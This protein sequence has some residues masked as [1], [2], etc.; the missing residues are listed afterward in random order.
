VYEILDNLSVKALWGSSYVPPSP[1]QLNG[2]MIRTNG[3]RG[4]PDLDSQT[5]NTVEGAV[6]YRYG[7]HVSLQ[8]TGFWTAIENRIESVSVGS[9]EEARNLTRSTTFGAEGVAELIYAPFFVKANVSWQQ[10]S[11]E[12]PED[13]PYWWSVV[14]DPDGPGGDAPPSA[15]GIMGHLW[16]G[17]TLPEYHV[18]GTVMLH[19]YGPRKATHQ[20]IVEAG[21]AYE[22]DPYVRLDLNLRTLQLELLGDRLTEVSLH[23]TNLLGTEYVEGGYLGVEIPAVGRTVFLK[24]TQ[25]F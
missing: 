18:Q 8:G 5:A 2:V 15:P 25:Q 6:L 4:N 3:L 11:V 24:L 17:V 12:Q 10:T 23:A 19:A 22:L 14:Y 1:S 7:E 9:A 13:A 16:A 20:N 21:E